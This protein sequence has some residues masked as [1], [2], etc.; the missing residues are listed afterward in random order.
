M[1]A[2]AA[3]G[4]R[5]GAAGSV[6]DPRGAV[7]L[8]TGP[9][10]FLNERVVGA[11]RREVARLVPES[12]VS[13][14]SGDQ[15][16][17]ASWG[18][19]TAPSLF[20]ATRCVVVRRLED[21]AEELHEGLLAYAGDPDPEIALVLVHSGGPKGSGLLGRLRK[22]ASVHEHR[23]EQVRPSALGQFVQAEA[24]AHRSRLDPA[25]AGLLIEA[26]GADLRALAAAV[27]QLAH[28]FPEQPITHETVSRYFS[29]RAAVKG[30]EIADHALAGRTA[31]AL[32]ELR[33]GLATGVSGPAI[34]GSLASSVRSLARFVTARRGLRDAD[35]AREI[36]APPWKVAL[37]RA[38]ARGWDPA[39]LA[40][41]VQAVARADAEVKGAGTDPAYALERMVLT[42]CAAR[43]ER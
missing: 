7:L 15:L 25:A 22:V 41:A 14:T 12:E 36:G 19:V 24:A 9:E 27:D 26:V 30:Y 8:V 35:L 29:G 42:V 16:T 3:A 23:S 4:T 33:W 18:E 20:S 31:T 6:S 40:A 32:E 43:V 2:R 13:E 38:Q 28:D 11:V 5:P 37:V 21:L 39:G 1:A 17:P 34:T 10:E